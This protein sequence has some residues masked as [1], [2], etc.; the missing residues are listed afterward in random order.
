MT[1]LAALGAGAEGFRWAFG[2]GVGLAVL[3]FALVLTLPA[4]NEPTA[5]ASDEHDAATRSGAAGVGSH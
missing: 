5:E 1:V 3:T 2:V 4:R